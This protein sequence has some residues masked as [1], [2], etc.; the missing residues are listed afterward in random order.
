MFKLS[1]YKWYDFFLKTKPKTTE[2]NMFSP[3]TMYSCTFSIV[4]STIDMKKN[5]VEGIYLKC[6]SNFLLLK[7]SVPDSSGKR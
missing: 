4:N 1:L 6:F 7:I 2:L 5:P 3:I